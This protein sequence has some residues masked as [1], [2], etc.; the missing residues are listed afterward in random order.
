[1]TASPLAV[2]TENACRHYTMGHSLIRAVDGISLEIRSGEYVALLGVSGSG[3]SSLLNLIA[4][5][6]RPTLRNN[7]GWR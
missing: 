6:D 4:G 7:F 1:M 5:L 3:K 2:Q